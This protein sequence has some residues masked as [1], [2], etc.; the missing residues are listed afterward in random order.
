MEKT[1]ERRESAQSSLGDCGNLPVFSVTG[2]V[3]VMSWSNIKGTNS[4]FLFSSKV[5]THLVPN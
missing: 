2:H 3:T 4:L 5:T 1:H